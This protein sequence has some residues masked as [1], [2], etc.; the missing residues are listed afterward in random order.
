MELLCTVALALK[1]P[2]CVALP[3]CAFTICSWAGWHQA[4]GRSDWAGAGLCCL[5]VAAGSCNAICIASWEHE[6][7]CC[8]LFGSRSPGS[9]RSGGGPSRAD[10]ASTWGGGNRFEPSAPRRGGFEDRDRGGGFRDRDD[11]GSLGPA[12]AD[13]EDRWSKK[14]TPGEPAPLRRG[15]SSSSGAADGEDRWSR[16]TSSM[17]DADPPASG[18]RPRI[19]LAPRSLPPPVLKVESQPEQKQPAATSES[20]AEA[21][22]AP[23]GPPKPKSNPFGAARPREEVLKEQ[24]RDWQ[25]EEFALEHKRVNRCVVRVNK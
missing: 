10:E 9:D 19:K 15:P 7:N 24:G 20:P 6:V 2:V 8:F 18:E 25:K 21:A 3:T 14:F 23:S 5:I 11:A 4:G 12:R 13:E 22:P 1:R 16:S 17:R